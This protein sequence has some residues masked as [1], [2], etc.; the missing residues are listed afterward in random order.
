MKH[1]AW[2]LLI[3]GVTLSFAQ[4]VA[5]VR[6]PV[7][8]AAIVYNLEMNMMLF[9]ETATYTSV[10]TEKVTGVDE[11][12][13]YSVELSQSNYRV[14]VFGEEGSVQDSDMPKPIYTYTPTGEVVAIKSDLQTPDVYRMAEMEAIHLPNKEVK[15]DDTWTFEVAGDAEKGTV[16]AKADYKVLDSETLSGTECWVV[17]V[18][19]AEQVGTN[20]AT[21]TGKIWLSKA[22]ASVLKLETAFNNAPV[23]GSGSAVGGSKKLELKAQ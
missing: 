9:G 20:P 16:K 2:L 3:V 13:N 7:K 4:G 10:L 23:P 8:D 18:D 21:L 15:K 5:L 1:F 11:K 19:Y 12:G 6:K 17:Q 14:E 22:D